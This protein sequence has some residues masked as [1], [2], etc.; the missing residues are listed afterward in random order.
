MARVDGKYEFGIARWAPSDIEPGERDRQCP[1]PPPTL[2]NPLP[3]LS[4]RR[5]LERAGNLLRPL[6]PNDWIEGPDQ[7]ALW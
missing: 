4:S 5:T 6:A 3:A 7:F 2:T 1:P